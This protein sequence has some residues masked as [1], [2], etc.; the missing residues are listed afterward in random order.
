MPSG[1][2]QGDG[3]QP[4]SVSQIIEVLDKEKPRP[5]GPNDQSVAW[6]GTVVGADEFSPLAPRRR[7][8][9]KWLVAGVLGAG[10]IGGGAYAMWPSSEEGAPVPAAKPVVATPD[11]PPPPAAKSPPPEAKPVPAA[12]P[13]PEAKPKP[14]P[15]AAIAEPAAPADAGV[16][17]ADAATAAPAKKRPHIKKKPPTKAKPPPP[18]PPQHK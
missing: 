1:G 18:P 14:V 12:K 7:G 15:A 13:P 2:D 16:A 4:L 10:A 6:K 3:T 9:A 11:E 8:R 17:P 5:V